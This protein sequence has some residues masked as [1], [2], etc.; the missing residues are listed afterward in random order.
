[1]RS[2]RQGLPVDVLVP[3]FPGRP[4]KGVVARFAGSLDSAS[5]TLLTE[6][7]LPNPKGELFPGMFGEVRFTFR[8]AEP[9][10]LLPSNA[11]IINATGTLVATVDASDRIRL[12]HVTFGRDFGNQV[13]I[14]HGL[15]VGA[16]VVANP[17]DSL[18]EGREVTPAM[19]QA[20][21]TP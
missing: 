1:V 9:A 14:L 13:E 11:A 8:A 4:F 2:V 10:I 21:K 19:P 5:R 18:T 15:D 17:S 20:A 7:N 6:V 12:V 3:E 16:R